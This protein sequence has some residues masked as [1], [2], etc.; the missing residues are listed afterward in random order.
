MKSLLFALAASAAAAVSAQSAMK[1]AAQLEWANP[2]DGKKI[3]VEP[4][5]RPDS[6]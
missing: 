5:E 3:V 1:L 4:Y 6:M 2:A